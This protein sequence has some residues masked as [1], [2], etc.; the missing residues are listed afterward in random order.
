[1]SVAPATTREDTVDSG[2]DAV[3]LAQKPA[4]A[5]APAANNNDPDLDIVNLGECCVTRES[6]AAGTLALG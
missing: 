5:I 1:M 3:A 4:S 6:P 2:V